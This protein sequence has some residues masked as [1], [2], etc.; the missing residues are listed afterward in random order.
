MYAEHKGWELSRI[1]VDVRYTV[2]ESGSG[3][4]TR[5][6]AVP[7]ALAADRRNRLA[8]IAERTPV[9][10]AISAGTPITTTIKAE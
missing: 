1:A 9:T 8:E 4:I 7:L 10:L 2:E 6:I 3:S 5:H